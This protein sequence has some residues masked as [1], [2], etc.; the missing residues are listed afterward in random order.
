MVGPSGE[1]GT[2]QK[3][4]GSTGRNVGSVCLR[5]GRG[6]RGVGGWEGP[7]LP[8]GRER[9]VSTGSSRR[10]GLSTWPEGWCRARLV[11]RTKIGVSFVAA[12]SVILIL[13]CCCCC[14]C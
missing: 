8:P 10:E 2:I 12:S 5:P 6:F 4:E 14:C 1:H 7:E 9:K 3:N 13:C 11:G